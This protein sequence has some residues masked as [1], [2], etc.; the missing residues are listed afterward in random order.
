VNGPPDNNRDPANVFAGRTCW[1]VTDGKVGDESPCLGLAEAMGLSPERRIVRPRRLFAALA[2]RGPIDPHERPAAPGSPIAPPFPDV[3]IASGRRTV[4]YLRSVRRASGGKTFTIFLKNP[5]V[6][7]SVADVVW[8]AAHDAARDLI[9]A[10]N[11][12]ISVAGPHR[13]S[14]KA[15]QHA[16]ENPDPR[17]AALPEPRMALLLGGDSRHHTFLEKDRRTLAG[18]VESMML[19]GAS[20]MITSSRRT[21]A[22]LISALKREIADNPKRAFLWTGGENNPYV[23]MLAH[24]QTILVTADS[25]NMVSEA[26]ATAAPVMVYEP[27]GGNPRLTGFINSLVRAGRVRKWLG[28]L[29]SWPCTPADAT[30]PMARDIARRYA[31]WRRQHEKQG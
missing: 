4:P 21:P 10:D 12:I 15:L 26:C 31:E 29:E 8:V 2:P 24:A 27:S 1:V 3:L 17:I 22:S 7:A 20:V 23:Q 19:A 13:V 18:A 5:R 14:E 16:R 11:V 30:V 25:T 28:R 6:S 9:R